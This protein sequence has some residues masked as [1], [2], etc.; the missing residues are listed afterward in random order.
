MLHIC[1]HGYCG[2]SKEDEEIE[3]RRRR[4]RRRV[5]PGDGLPD[6]V[7]AMIS[8]GQGQAVPTGLPVDK[9]VELDIER[10]KAEKSYQHKSGLHVMTSAIQLVDQVLETQ[11]PVN[12]T[13]MSAALPRRQ[14]ES[15]SVHQ[16]ASAYSDKNM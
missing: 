15:M 14:D 8:E 9:T 6:T 2:A 3:R 7:R 16:C 10:K 11:A 13:H 1:Y 4:A 5:R 12:T